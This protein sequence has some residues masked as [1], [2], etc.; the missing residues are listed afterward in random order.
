MSLDTS[1]YTAAAVALLVGLLLGFAATAVAFRQHWIP[2]PGSSLVDR[3]DRV[4]KLTPAQREQLVEILDETHVR[5]G[6]MRIE[7][8]RQRHK[9]LAETRGEITGILTPTQKIQFE[10]YFPVQDPTR[11]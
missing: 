5:V 2:V 8:D 10:H 3:M 6:Q 1:R 9:I 4:L 11:Q 7:F